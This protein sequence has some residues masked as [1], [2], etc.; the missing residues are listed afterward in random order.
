M[1][2]KHKRKNS[3]GYAWQSGDLVEGQ[4]GLNIADGTLH[5]KKA[6]NSTVT[7]AAGGG[8]TIFLLRAAAIQVLAGANVVQTS[9][10]T[11]LSGSAPGFSV[12]AGSINL[13]AGSYIFEV[14]ELYSTGTNSFSLKLRNTTDSSDIYTVSPSTTTINNVN[15][16]H[17]LPLT[18]VSFTLNSAKTVA[19]VSASGTSAH[20]LRN[21]LGNFAPISHGSGASS[22]QSHPVMIRIIKL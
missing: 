7:L 16:V 5:F 11:L 9:S 12:S 13:P 2:I 17:L 22:V 19:F 10:W 1:A 14:P 21:Y 4:I 18:R 8:P 6:D 15:N 20:D 3:T